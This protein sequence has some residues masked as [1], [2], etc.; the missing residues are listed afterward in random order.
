[1]SGTCVR[2]GSCDICLPL[3]ERVSTHM[4]LFAKEY[5]TMM[6]GPLLSSEDAVNCSV[7]SLDHGPYGRRHQPLFVN[8]LIVGPHYLDPQ[9]L[10][11]PLQRFGVAVKV[12]VQP[13]R[14]LDG[15]PAVCHHAP[16]V[17]GDVPFGPE[18]KAREALVI[19]LGKRA[20]HP[21]DETYI[22]VP[23]G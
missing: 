12:E 10:P 21:Q 16:T 19:R 1:M 22:R 2:D 13:L 23:K 4:R 5:N 14:T 15:T 7:Q 17:P 8:P 11:P 3:L 9:P 20:N 6:R 18:A